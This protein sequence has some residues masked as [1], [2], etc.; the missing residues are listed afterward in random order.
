MET[1]AGEKPEQRCQRQPPSSWLPGKP[2]RGPQPRKGSAWHWVRQGRAWGAA[3]GGQLLWPPPAARWK[4]RQQRGETKSESK[5][6]QQSH[7][8][9]PTDSPVWVGQEREGSILKSSQRQQEIRQ[10]VTVLTNLLISLFERHSLYVLDT[11]F[12]V[13]LIIG[14]VIKHKKQNKIFL[15]D[16]IQTPDYY[17]FFFCSIFV[18]LEDTLAHGDKNRESCCILYMGAGVQGGGGP[19]K[20]LGL[21]A[22]LPRHPSPPKPGA[23]PKGSRWQRLPLDPTAKEQPHRKPG[24]RST[25]R[26]CGTGEEQIHAEQQGAGLVLVQQGRGE[27]GDRAGA[28]RRDQ[29]RLGREE[30]VSGQG[31]QQ[32]VVQ[33][34]LGLRGIFKYQGGS[35]GQ[36]GAMWH[37][38]AGTPRG[39]RPQSSPRQAPGSA[40][41]GS[42]DREARLGTGRARSATRLL[43]RRWHR[44]GAARPLGRWWG[45]PQA[46]LPMGTGLASHHQAQ[47]PTILLRSN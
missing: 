14:Q 41:K 8:F 37:R 42:R 20:A 16:Y 6:S 33:K 25:L 38:E 32:G 27:H 35:G 5:V 31:S 13:P 23:M 40:L 10:Q 36:R 7:L 15:K 24:G 1:R 29:E 21:P 46:L 19:G 43:L 34:P 18:F 9:S 22:P 26:G 12:S 2:P 39:K 11:A 45:H 4:Q 44:C 3:G 28:T 47:A 30:M 17:L